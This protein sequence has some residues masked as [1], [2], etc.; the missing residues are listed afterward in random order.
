MMVFNDFIHKYKLKNETK[1]HIKTYP[2]LSSF[3][4]DSVEIFSSFDK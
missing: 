1:S 2:I 3:M 4:L